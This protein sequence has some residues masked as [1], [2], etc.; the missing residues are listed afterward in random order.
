MKDTKYKAT[1]VAPSSEL[2]KLLADY[3]KTK[4][5]CEQVYNQTTKNFDALY[6]VGYRQWFEQG[7][8]DAVR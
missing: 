1:T 4:R 7:G 8:I 3:P 2:G 6:P 5:L